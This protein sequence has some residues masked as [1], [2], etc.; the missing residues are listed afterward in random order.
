MILSLDISIVIPVFN[1]QD[2]LSVLLEKIKTTLHSKYTYEIILVDDGSTDNSWNVITKLKQ[3]TPEL[4]G[5][6]LSRNYGQHNAIMCGF[7]NAIGNFIITMDDDLQHPP[8][9]IIKLINT[10]TETNADLVYGLPINRKHSPV[11]K[12]GSYFVRKS[13]KYFADN[14]NGEGSSFRMIDAKTIKNIVNNHSNN[15]VFIDEVVHWY[16]SKIALVDVEHHERKHGKTGYSLIK[17]IKLYLDIFINYSANPLRIMI[18]GGLISSLVTFGF[19]IRFIIR[20]VSEGAPLGYTSVIVSILFSTSIIMLCL[21]I[22]GKYIFNLYNQQ[23]NKPLYRI[24]K[25]I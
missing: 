11:K 25:T 22:I 21:G 14:P 7:A 24:D 13:S 1:S 23:K 17:L 2:A 4:K 15:Y 16:T 10:Q 3:S 19:G 18:Y 5:I 6:K 12:A 8:E 20:K 9:E